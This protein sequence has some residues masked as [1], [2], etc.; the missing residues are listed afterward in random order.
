MTKNDFHNFFRDKTAIDISKFSR[1]SGVSRN[2]LEEA[3]RLNRNPREATKEKLLP[4]MIKY[5]FKNQS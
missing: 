1:E 3:I 4:I 5:G 2:T